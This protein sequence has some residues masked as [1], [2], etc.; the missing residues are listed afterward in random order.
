MASKML[1]VEMKTFKGDSGK[2]SGKKKIEESYRENF[3]CLTE[4]YIIMN[5]MLPE[6]WMNVKGASNEVSDG[7]EKHVFGNS[8]KGN[9]YH[10][11]TEL[12]WITFYFFCGK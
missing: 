10:K 11:V 1:L 9:L 8:R 7:N 6:M 5:R 12:G 3:C 4:T 2:D